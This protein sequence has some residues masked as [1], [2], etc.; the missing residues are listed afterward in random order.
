VNE[1]DEVVEYLLEAVVSKIG[2]EKVRD[3][4]LIEWM[5]DPKQLLVDLPIMYEKQHKRYRCGVANLEMY[6]V[7]AETENRR[8]SS[9][10]CDSAHLLEF[11][12]LV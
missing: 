6:V 5:D 3:E 4:K 2:A 9:L 8:Y 7:S 11:F 12:F 1:S 10:T